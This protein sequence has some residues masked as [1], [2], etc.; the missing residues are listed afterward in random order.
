[1]ISQP[2]SECPECPE[3][4]RPC[5]PP[6]PSLDERPDAN[7]P[8]QGCIRKRA[9]QSPARA[10]RARSDCN[11]LAGRLRDYTRVENDNTRMRALAPNWE[12]LRRS[13]ALGAEY[14]PFGFLLMGGER[15][16]KN[17][18]VSGHDHMTGFTN[19]APQ[20]RSSSPLLSNATWANGRL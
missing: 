8:W 14:E 20:C 16:R 15:L 6:Y 17:D 19:L 9:M 18:E 1:M 3:T 10:P 4:A 2:P 13:P 5:G 11:R 7:D 12:R